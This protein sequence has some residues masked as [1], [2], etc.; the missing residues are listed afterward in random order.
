MKFRVWEAAEFHLTINFTIGLRKI[1]DTK[2][3]IQ[4]RKSAK[5]YELKHRPILSNSKLM[6]H[7]QIYI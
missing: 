1:E 7:L 4:F 3:D 6:L 5:E 2:K